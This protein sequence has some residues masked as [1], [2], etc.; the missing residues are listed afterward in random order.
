MK[1]T[2]PTSTSD[3]PVDDQ[4]R[5]EAVAQIF[6][7]QADHYERLIEVSKRFGHMHQTT[8]DA[9]VNRHYVSQ[10]AASR[11]SV[12]GS[13]F[14]PCLRCKNFGELLLTHSVTSAPKKA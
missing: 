9:Y 2:K 13:P 7:F 5:L 1:T 4:A 10:I 3:Q 8:T 6:D 11:F 14:L 12:D